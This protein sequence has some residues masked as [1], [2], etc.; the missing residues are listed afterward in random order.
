MWYGRG[1][2]G[3][4][5]LRGLFVKGRRLALVFREDNTVWRGNCRRQDMER[6]P[7]HEMSQRVRDNRLRSTCSDPQQNRAGRLSHRPC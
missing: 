1:G 7:T 6:K 2:R 3:G 4:S 5:L